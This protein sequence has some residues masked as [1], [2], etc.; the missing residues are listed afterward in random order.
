MNYNNEKY[1][2][3]QTMKDTYILH[4]LWQTQSKSKKKY[5]NDKE[6]E[7]YFIEDLLEKYPNCFI[8]KCS[9]DNN[10]YPYV[11]FAKNK[12]ISK[13]NSSIKSRKES[14]DNI[15]K[16][17]P[18]LRMLKNGDPE[19]PL[20]S[21]D[22]NVENILIYPEIDFTPKAVFQLHHVCYKNGKSE[23][24]LKKEPSKY[25]SSLDLTD[26]LNSYHQSVEGI[27]QILLCQLMTETGHSTLH[28][29]YSSDNLQR[30]LDNP[31]GYDTS[32]HFLS[33]NN[34]NECL[35]YIESLG[36]LKEHLLTY[37]EMLE[38]NLKH[39]PVRK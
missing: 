3:T 30:Y 25:I 17:I 32:Y 4:S 15:K 39:V 2:K 13:K 16:N 27:N 34:Y 38:I 5:L 8:K 11:D 20:K 35:S 7:K 31:I 23:G 33:E 24:K 19:K 10:L 28:Q 29:N 6:Y 9:Y 22:D 1:I 26:T 12:N 36:Y 37:E 18:I 21:F 14:K